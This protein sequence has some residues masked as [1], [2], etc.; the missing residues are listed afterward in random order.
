MKFIGK[1]FIMKCTFPEVH[2]VLTNNDEATIMN[3]VLNPRL[4]LIQRHIVSSW[5]AWVDDAK[6]IC[7]FFRVAIQY[8]HVG[9]FSTTVVFFVLAKEGKASRMRKSQRLYEMARRTT[10]VLTLPAYPMARFSM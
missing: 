2:L 3:I 10:S 4:D 7:D 1:Y 9:G 5:V 8:L 6:Y